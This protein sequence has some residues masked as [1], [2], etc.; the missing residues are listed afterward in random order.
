MSEDEKRLTNFL[1]DLGIEGVGHTG[2]TYLAHLMSL[3]R[4]MQAQG[5]G[6]EL[7]RA[8]M[9]HSI[10]GTE[11]FQGFKLPLESRDEIRALIGERAERLAYLNCAMD[12][13]AFDRAVAAG[14]P[15]FLYRDRITGEV[16]TLSHEDFDDL[17][18]IHL[19][20]WLEQVPRS[21][22]GWDYR[23]AAYRGMAERLGGTALA[24]YDRV[25]AAEAASPPSTPAAHA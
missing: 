25:F 22:W 11:R 6:E 19:F 23:R 3:F 12:R 10:Y 15:P 7:C 24:T 4:L 8:G 18:R 21:R 20:D 5:C 14:V 2:K 13:D 1:V 16:I 17:C 9:F